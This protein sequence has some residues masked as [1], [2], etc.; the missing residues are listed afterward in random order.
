MVS[1][2]SKESDAPEALEAN[3]ELLEYAL[4]SGHELDE[5]LKQAGLPGCSVHPP[6]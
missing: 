4:Y 5:L 3:A 1:E 6:P 2:A